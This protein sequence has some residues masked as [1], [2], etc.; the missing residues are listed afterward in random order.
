[1]GLVTEV[2][3][4]GRELLRLRPV[5]RTKSANE[6]Q[7]LLLSLYVEARKKGTDGGSV[8][9]CVASF[10]APQRDFGA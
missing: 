10:K 2:R 9:E 3:I 7:R 6:M 4:T 8:G 5:Y 1:M